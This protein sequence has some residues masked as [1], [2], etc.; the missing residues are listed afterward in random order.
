MKWALLCLIFFLYIVIPNVEQL[1]KLLEQLQ[2]NWTR[3]ATNLCIPH[4]IIDGI[5]GKITVSECLEDVL[6]NW[7]TNSNDLEKPTFEVL[8]RALESSAVGNRLLANQI[9]KDVEVLQLLRVSEKD[10]G[11][12]YM[13]S[14]PFRVLASTSLY[15]K[16]LLTICVTFFCTSS[17]KECTKCF[18]I[19]FFFFL[20]C[21]YT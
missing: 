2:A 18:R 19:Y 7:I 5:N 4:W 11:C 10:A 8:V 6:K 1:A 20:M 9:S 14:Q 13:Y 3:L 21:C 17:Y 16:V 15:S 12:L